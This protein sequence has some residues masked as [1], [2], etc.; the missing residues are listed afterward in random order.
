MP[1]ELVIEE[2]FCPSIFE[3]SIPDDSVVL[4]LKWN[5]PVI[6]E[7]EIMSKIDLY[8]LDQILEYLKN[9]G[10]E[11]LYST[12]GYHLN[13]DKKLPHIHHNFICSSLPD[14]VYKLLTQNS[15]LHRSRWFNKKYENYNA[16]VFSQVTYRWHKK[17]DVES[18]KY[19]TLSYPLKEGHG[20]ISQFPLG[21]KNI[22]DDCYTFLLSCGT[23]IYNKEYG[24]HIRQQK[25][26]ERKKNSLIE[27]FDLL[28]NEKFSTYKEMLKWLDSNY[29]SK[30][31][32]TE[33][34]DPKNYKTNC[35]KVG[36]KLGLINYSDF[37]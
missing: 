6:E 1:I 37:C 29:I 30:L 16:S 19:S 34:P 24:L 33:Y 20:L 23:A 21:Y 18:P 11:I 31:L 22:S 3:D 36:V 8:P 7:N 26:E 4:N 12:M 17:I 13:G 28:K 32:I 2:D 25:C 14:K 5:I 15:S 35:Q 9:C 10:L 27:L